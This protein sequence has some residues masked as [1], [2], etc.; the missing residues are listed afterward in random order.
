M[1]LKLTV[2]VTLIVF[3]IFTSVLTLTVFLTTTIVPNNKIT[4]NTNYYSCMFLTF[5]IIAGTDSWT[6]IDSFLSLIEIMI[7]NL[8]LLNLNENLSPGIGL[9]LTL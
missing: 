7:Y 9:G 4:P 8:S 5:K 2:F 3:L 6:Y 1:F